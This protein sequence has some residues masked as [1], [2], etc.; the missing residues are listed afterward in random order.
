MFQA[1]YLCV[2]SA[3]KWPT[4]TWALRRHPTI[5]GADAA[6]RGGHG[7]RHQRRAGAEARGCRVCDGQ[8]GDTGELCGTAPCFVRSCWQ[9]SGVSCVLRSS[10]S[11]VQSIGIWC[12]VAQSQSSLSETETWLVPWSC[13]LSKLCTFLSK[14]LAA[15]RNKDTGFAIFDA[16]GI[17]HDHFILQACGSTQ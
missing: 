7:R 8:N 2:S 14:L 11:A 5:A 9:R 17:T 1:R 13:V 15:P 6:D 4:L 16:R 12:C 3:K 10:M